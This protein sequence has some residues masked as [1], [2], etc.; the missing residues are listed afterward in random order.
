M[1]AGL[2]RLVARALPGGSPTWFQELLGW[3]LCESPPGE[4][5]ARL[6]ALR[7]AVAGHPMCDVLLGRIADRWN[8]PSMVRFLAETGIPA[9]QSI[10][11]ELL[12]RATLSV[13]PRLRDEHDI[14]E[15]FT[16]LG[17]TPEQAAWLNTLPL[18]AIEAWTDVLPTRTLL[19]HAARLTAVRAA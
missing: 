19:I 5:T 12:H 3:V 15:T 9:Q 2:E 11:H 6:L 13:L 18:E 10:G 4:R 16:D 14:G 17:V 1:D 7:A 8:D